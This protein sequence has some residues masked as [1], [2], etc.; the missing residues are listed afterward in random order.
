LIVIPARSQEYQSGRIGQPDEFG[1]LARI[2]QMD[3]A[4]AGGQIIPMVDAD[5]RPGLAD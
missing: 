3:D 5:R 1:S 2:V 4:R